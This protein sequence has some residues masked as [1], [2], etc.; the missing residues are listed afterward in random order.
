MNLYHF[1]AITLYMHIQHH[2]F[3]GVSLKH[4][5]ANIFVHYN[6]LAIKV[7]FLRNG[8]FLHAIT[9]F[10]C[11]IMLMCINVWYLVCRCKMVY[12]KQQHTNCNENMRL[13]CTRLAN[14]HT[15]QQPKQDTLAWFYSTYCSVE[16]KTD[17]ITIIGH[18]KWTMTPLHWLES[19]PKHNGTQEFW[20]NWPEV[21]C[22]L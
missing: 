21:Y 12:S 18:I 8:T 4:C 13:K 5:N 19:E 1:H 20:F 14:K 11:S 2:K 3:N 6:S 15:I 17:W 22:L 9:I 16:K 10:K 7:L